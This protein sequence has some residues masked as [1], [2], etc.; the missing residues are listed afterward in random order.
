MI[1]PTAL[2]RACPRNARS[3]A[4]GERKH[5]CKGGA[6]LFICS[7]GLGP[8]SLLCPT[9]LIARTSRFFAGVAVDGG[10][11]DA[12]DDTFDDVA[13]EPGGGE[14]F[15]D[16]D[17]EVCAGMHGAQ[18]CAEGQA[19]A[20]ALLPALAFVMAGEEPNEEEGGDGM[21]DKA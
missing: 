13:H 3:P 18:E 9:L 16:G 20:D 2:L 11:G 7:S 4:R 1:P 21:D 15:G 19:E 14:G 12:H 8:A 17:E 6:Q 10:G 5:A